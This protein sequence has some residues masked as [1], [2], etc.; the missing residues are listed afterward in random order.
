MLFSFI[1]VFNFGFYENG[2]AY[3]IC[4]NNGEIVGIKYYSSKKND[5]ITSLIR[6]KGLKGTV[7]NRAYSIQK[8]LVTRNHNVRVRLIL[9]WFFLWNNFSSSVILRSTLF[10]TLNLLGYI[11]KTL[12]KKKINFNVLQFFPNV[13]KYLKTY[14]SLQCI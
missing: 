11:K 7:V 5:N 8:W 14:I 3:F 10:N 9:I 4:R 13:N 1:I 2:L 12:K 6:Y